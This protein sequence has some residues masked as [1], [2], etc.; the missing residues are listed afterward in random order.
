MCVC[1]LPG[2]TLLNDHLDAQTSARLL[3]RAAA[4]LG[5]T[6]KLAARLDVQPGELAPWLAGKAFPP[7]P[8]F[9]AAL[10]LILDA[11]CAAV[12]RDAG[13]PRLLIADSEDGCRVLARILGDEFALVPVHT[14]TDALDLVQAA[15]VVKGRALGAVVCGQHFEGSQMF[16][17]LECMKA[18]APTRSLPFICCRARP[19]RLTGGALAAMREACEALGAVAY[20]DL[21]EIERRAGAEAAAVE[22]RDAVRAATRFEPKQRALRILVVDDNP[23]AAHTLTMLL[24]MAGHDVHKASGGEQ[25]LA[26]GAELRPQAAIL[27]IGMQGMSGYEL[28][29]RMRR[30][31]WGRSVVLIAVTGWGAAEDVARA[32]ASGFDHHFRKPVMVERVL[33]VLPK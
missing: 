31:G 17:F 2:T 29:E 24:K 32:Q 27:D 5:S 11:H 13:K 7:Q 22:F 33:E 6:E 8:V 14:L 26:L 3:K 20:I 10:E 9:E 1:R 4:N 23:D 18:Y 15:A 28:A 30:E 21:P 16:R 12:P 25:A 19:T